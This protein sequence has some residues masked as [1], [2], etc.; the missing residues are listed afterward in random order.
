MIFAVAGSG[1][2][3][4]IVSGLDLDRRFLLITY[5]DSNL[6][7]LRRK[8]I[9]RFGFFPA[10]IVLH[11]YFTFLHV[12]CYKP[13]LLMQMRTKGINFDQPPQWTQKLKRTAD[14]FYVDSRQRLYHNR[15]ATLL[16]T[17]GV[18]G[19]VTRRIEK[20]F[21]VVCVDEVQDIG[22]YDFELLTAIC[23]CDV[24]TLLVGDF[25][26][27][28]YVT[29]QDGQKNKN[30]HDDFEKYKKRFEKAGVTVDTS[31]LEKSYRC[32]QTVCDF[33]REHLGIDIY[34]H[35][36]HVTNATLLDQQDDADQFHACKNTVK[37]FYQEHQKYGCYSQNWGSSKGV[38][39]YQDVCVVLNGSAYKALMNGS[40]SNV[41]PQTRN[42][43]YVAC[44]RP[45]GNLYL[46]PDQMFK[47]FKHESVVG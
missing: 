27:H 47:K 20:Y 10:N 31:S 40:M 21:D 9:E 1:K 5:T 36:D 34:S 46:I 29:S 12:F 15:I 37:L 28:T 8:I 2:T 30:L 41:S 11:S 4:R 42:K 18:L 19:D 43:L 39:H 32:S 17:K 26:Q 14:I 16:D 23:G 35:F 7:N 25:Y 33:I 44:S 6:L 38:D 45:H 24:D 3:T 13:F 22:G